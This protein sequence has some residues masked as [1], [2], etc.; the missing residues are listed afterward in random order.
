MIKWRA[1]IAAG[2]LGGTAC[3][4]VAGPLPAEA[5]GAKQEAERLNKLPPVSAGRT[6]HIDHS[7][8]N[9]KGRASYY[10]AHFRNRKMADGHPMNPNADVAAS[11]TLPLGSIAKVTNL[12][13]GRSAT[14]RIEDRGPY[15]NGRVVDL[16]PKVAADLDIKHKG[17]VPV[18]VKPITMPQP[19]GTVVLGAGAA[20]ASPQE[21]RQAVE[22]TKG[23]TG[24]K[25]AET[26]EK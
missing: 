22:A 4:A 19:N 25:P 14:V 10:A 21:V 15:R 3:G 26:A 17:I 23:L 12:D 11:K 24:Q 7:G 1:A 2:L 6:G 9:E 18:E 20:D 16:A 8:R 13:N 5:P